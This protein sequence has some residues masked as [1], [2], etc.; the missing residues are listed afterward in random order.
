MGV[1]EYAPRASE[2][3]TEETQ[4]EA[5]GCVTGEDALTGEKF[6]RFVDDARD[7]NHWVA[8]VRVAGGRGDGAKGAL[9]PLDSSS[10]ETRTFAAIY[11]SISLIVLPI[12][13]DGICGLDVMC[14]MLGLKREKEV[15]QALRWE[16]GAFVLRHV[17]NRALIQSLWTLGELKRHLGSCELGAAGA[18]VLADASHDT[19]HGDGNGGDGHGDSQVALRSYTDE[20]RLAVKWKCRLHAASPE[21]IL[22]I[23][24]ALPEWTVEQVVS[25]YKDRRPIQNPAPRT[26][27]IVKRD[28]SNGVKLK[29]ACRFHDGIEHMAHLHGSLSSH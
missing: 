24:R 11:L 12:I 14:L 4:F 8:G 29:A 9:A 5:V 21:S 15:R 22:G 25:E 16:L 10:D 20:E 1:Q 23:L 17:G 6:L 26:H 27:Y 28:T 13:A 7:V 18:V 3:I 19:R 2:A